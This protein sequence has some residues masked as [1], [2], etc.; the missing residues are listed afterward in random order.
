[1]PRRNRPDYSGLCPGFRASTAELMG[2]RPHQGHSP[3]VERQPLRRGIATAS[4][5]AA[6]PKRKWPM[7]LRQS[8]LT[9]TSKRAGCYQSGETVVGTTPKEDL[10]CF[11]L[12]DRL[13]SGGRK[14]VQ[15]NPVAT[16]QRSCVSIHRRLTLMCEIHSV[17]AHGVT[18]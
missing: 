9:L 17:Q 7:T 1:M 16:S 15:A 14:A 10:K 3:K 18:H 6:K 11:Q 4:H 13:S 12:G 5:P 2:Q 8:R